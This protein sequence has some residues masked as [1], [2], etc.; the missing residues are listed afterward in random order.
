M[1]RAWGLKPPKCRSRTVPGRAGQGGG[2]KGGPSPPQPGCVPGPRGV[3]PGARVARRDGRSCAARPGCA[4][5][6]LYAPGANYTTIKN[7]EVTAGISSA[8]FWEHERGRRAVKEQDSCYEYAVNQ[9]NPPNQHLSAPRPSDSRWKW[10]HVAI[11]I[12][13]LGYRASLGKAKL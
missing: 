12:V 7:Q 13:S 5:A 11:P 3:S 10:L 2:G 9:F 6:G 1:R 8:S 4:K